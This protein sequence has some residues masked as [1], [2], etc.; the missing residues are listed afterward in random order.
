M[1]VDGGETWAPAQ[2]E[3]EGLG[4][5]AWRRWSFDWEPSEPGEYTLSC[6]A[7]DSAGNEQPDEP[8]WNLGGYAN[9]SAQRLRVTVA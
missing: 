5:W 9:N 1:S 3:D 8:Q 6:R 2:L 7:R 4:D